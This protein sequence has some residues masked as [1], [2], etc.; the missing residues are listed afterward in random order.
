MPRQVWEGGL[1]RWASTD[2]ECIQDDEA[3]P[4]L[5]W[6]NTNVDPH[7]RLRTGRYRST[8]RALLHGNQALKICLQSVNLVLVVHCCASCQN[9][10]FI[11]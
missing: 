2:A 9:N 4:A 8:E 11:L 10:V 1:C 5:L 7:H 3:A 6:S